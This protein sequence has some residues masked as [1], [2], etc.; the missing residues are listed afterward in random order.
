MDKMID[1]YIYRGWSQQTRH[2]NTTVRL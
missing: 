2:G 1:K